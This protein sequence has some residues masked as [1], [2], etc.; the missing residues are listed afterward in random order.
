MQKSLAEFISLQSRDRTEANLRSLVI[1][2][3]DGEREREE[4]SNSLKP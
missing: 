2:H 1:E 4:S 3:Q